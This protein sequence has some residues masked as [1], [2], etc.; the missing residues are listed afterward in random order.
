MLFERLFRRFQNP[1]DAQT[2]LPIVEG[3]TAVL[4][5][6]QEISGFELKRLQFLHLRRPHIAASITDQK[7]VNPEFCLYISAFVIHPYFFSRI[8]IIPYQHL[9]LT[10]NE[11][12]AHL[13]RREPID[14]DVREYIIGEIHRQMRNIFQAV[15]MCAA[16]RHHQIRLQPDSDNP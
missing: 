10:P 16:R 7:L 5:A 1:H 4:D 9:L 3:F 2:S 15:H 6:I 14:V 8:Q 13:N 12:R 11:R